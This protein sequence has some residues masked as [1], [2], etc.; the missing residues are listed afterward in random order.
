M[1]S[2]RKRKDVR[3]PLGRRQAMGGGEAELRA[4]SIVGAVLGGA[5][6]GLV[7]GLHGLEK[8]AM[9]LSNEAEERAAILLFTITQRRALGFVPDNAIGIPPTSSDEQM[10]RAQSDEFK[11]NWRRIVRTMFQYV[12]SH[13]PKLH[14][15]AFRHP[16][17]G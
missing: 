5:F 1:A 8:P 9:P 11:S 16:V 10:F 3:R 4:A 12:F 17:S 15:P 7:F 6:H 2:S 14:R 13:E